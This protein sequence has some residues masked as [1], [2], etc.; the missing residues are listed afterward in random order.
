MEITQTQDLRAIRIV[1]AAL[2]SGV[3]FFFISGL[4]IIL[5]IGPLFDGDKFL[6]QLFLIVSTSF[7]VVGIPSG[8]LIFKKR[9]SGIENLD[10]DEKISVYRSAM[11]LRASILEGLGFLF[12]ICF[13]Q[14]G[15]KILAVEIVIILALMSFY[16]P[17]DSRLAEEMKHDLREIERIQEK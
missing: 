14:T 4:F 7:A 9:I 17:T 3:L 5:Q 8:I 12:L 10:F 2:M 16:F 13:M 1:Y 6:E 11:I 15:S